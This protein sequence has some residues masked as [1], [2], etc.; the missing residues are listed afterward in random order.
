MRLTDPATAKATLSV[1]PLQPHFG[2]VVQP[3]GP[4]SVA[5]LDPGALARMLRTHG[6][7]HVTGFNASREAFDDLSR[8]LGGTAMTYRGGGYIRSAVKGAS[9]PTLLS[10]RYDHG[11]AR[12]QT[13]GL[14]LHGEMYY[15]DN[16]PH[17]LWFYC[18]RPAREAGGTTICDGIRVFERLKPGWQALLREKRL[19]YDRYYRDGE[20]QKIYQTDDIAD[21]RAFCA[22]N[23]LTTVFDAGTGALRTSYLTSALTTPRW[24]EALAY[25]NNL[26]P[27][28]WQ[29]RMGRKT[30]IV[31]F[32]DDSVV[33][34]A[35]IKDVIAI[36]R[37][38]MLVLRWWAGDFAVLD[39]SRALHGREAFDDPD[40]E[41]FLRM[42]RDMPF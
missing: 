11:R 39:N 20:W 28:I 16:R 7:V 22:G 1:R 8:A 5:D 10:T 13:F 17:V 37:E 32:E 4:G 38:E 35:L 27:V 41:V 2:V 9:E 30:S 26:L 42:M 40:R 6:A 19:R 21:A 25:M 29:E 3:A 18:E 31:R 24:T 36:Q 12:Q 23:G 14:P 15:V 34:D 33:P